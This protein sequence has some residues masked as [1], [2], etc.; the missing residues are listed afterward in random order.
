MQ[1]LGQPAS[2]NLSGPMTVSAGR[3]STAGPPPSYPQGAQLPH[4]DARWA[5]SGRTRPLELK[6]RVKVG[7]NLFQVPAVQRVPGLHHLKPAG[8]A[9]GV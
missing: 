5:T 1:V 3:Q 9:V 6:H 8:D 4:A 2:S 7:N